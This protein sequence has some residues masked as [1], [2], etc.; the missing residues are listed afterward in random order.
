MGHAGDRHV[1]EGVPPLQWPGYWGSIEITGDDQKGKNYCSCCHARL[2]DHDYSTAVHSVS[3][4]SG[5]G[6]DE[7]DW[8][9]P[10]P[11]YRA[12]KQGVAIG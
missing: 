10:H 11:D 1:Y 12:G 2:G 9:G 8:Q 3:Q 7:E 4:Y 6:P 5:P